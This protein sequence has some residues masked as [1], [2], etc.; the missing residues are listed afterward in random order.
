MRFLFIT[1]LVL[2]LIPVKAQVV[3]NLERCREMALE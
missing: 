2:G 1:L 3:L